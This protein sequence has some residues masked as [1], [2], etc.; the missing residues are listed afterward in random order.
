VDPA[1]NITAALALNPQIILINMPSNDVANGYTSTETMNNFAAVINAARAAGVKVILTG[2][3][4]RGDIAL[5]SR[6][7]LQSQNQ[8]LLSTYGSDAVNIY[9]ELTDLSDPSASNYY[10]IKPSYGYGDKIHINDAGHNYIYTQ[11]FPPVKAW[12]EANT[13]GFVNG[14]GPS[15]LSGSLNLTT[16]ATAS[17]P[18]GT[19][20]ISTGGSTLSSPNYQITYSDG[21]LTVTNGPASTITS[22]NR[23]STFAVQEVQPDKEVSLTAW[24]NPMSDKATIRFTVKDNSTPVKVGLFNINGVLC[25]EVYS[26][27]VQAGTQINV[28][29]T[30]TEL[31][32]GVYIVKLQSGTEFLT[33][34]IVVAH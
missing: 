19:Y 23:V 34:K 8:T 7:I 21:I 33:K 4:P 13:S 12:I 28:T 5:A 9:D 17:S 10:G 29:V 18:V 16:T 27:Y 15:S 3:Q 2:T 25:K 11:M 22:S 26:G 30:G 14:D 31:P 32:S 24:P 6:Q 1:R 20:T